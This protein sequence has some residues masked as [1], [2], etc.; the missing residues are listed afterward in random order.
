[1]R[2]PASKRWSKS[3]KQRRNAIKS[4]QFESPP[5]APSMMIEKADKDKKPKT[6]K[7]G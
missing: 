1:M 3:V 2:P 7:T 6:E 4:Y 5:P